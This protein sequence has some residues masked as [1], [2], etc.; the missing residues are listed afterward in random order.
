MDLLRDNLEGKWTVEE[1]NLVEEILEQTALALENARLVDQIR[2][3]SDQTQLLQAITSR[4]ATLPEETFLL[5]F[6]AKTLYDS[7][8]LTNC[9]IETFDESNTVCLLA[10]NIPTNEAI[11]NSYNI[12]GNEV[13]LEVIRTRQPLILYDISNLSSIGKEM[14]NMLLERG[15]ATWIV[16]PLAARGEV[17]GTI[18]LEIGDPDRIITDEDINLFNQVSGQ[19]STALDGSRLLKAEQL[20]RQ[21]AGALLEITQ[22]AGASLDLKYVLKEVTQR[23]ASAIRANGCAI[24]LIG[25]DGKTLILI[26]SQ[27]AQSGENQQTIW[28]SFIDSSDNGFEEIT[29]FAQVIESQEP[30]VFDKNMN[31]IL[32]SEKWRA[33]ID[34]EKL[35]VV[36][37]VS[38]NVA[39]GLMV[40]DHQSITNEFTSENIALALTIAGQMATTVDNATLCE[41]TVRRAERESL[42]AGITSKIRASN[43]PD[44]IMKTAISELKQALN[45]LEATVS[46]K[47][48][49]T[50]T[51]SNGD[52]TNGQELNDSDKEI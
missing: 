7:L 31:P 2:L 46:I 35:L 5:D 23:S 16:L 24:F 39:I 25:E 6:I 28:H 42:V 33:D 15:T 40:Y 17:I 50:V 29:L 49:D 27:L 26:M 4:A 32:M 14:K 47:E 18:N 43:D 44:T 8:N 3:R 38:K 41:Q 13:T 51:E 10:A 52:S 1:E 37:L 11:G 12:A 20:G 45:P 9:S 36:P 34:S 19:V 21:S 48:K 30:L 22:I